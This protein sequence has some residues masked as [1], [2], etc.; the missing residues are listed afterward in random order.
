MQLRRILTAFFIL[1]LFLVSSLSV[2]ARPTVALQSADYVQSGTLNLA[3]PNCIDSFSQFTTACYQ[4]WY[5]LQTMF[6]DDGVPTAIGLDHVAVQ[7]YSSNS[8][9]SV[10]YFNV[11]PG[12]TWSDDVP[13][14]AT[15]LAYSIQQMFANYSWAAG[16]LLT[17]I[18]L[19]NGSP[20]T[21][22]PGRHR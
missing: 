14:N 4:P 10:W 11:T 9:G 6:P 18:G 13:A 21:A 5:F 20:Q 2:V 17:Y 12:M 7:S 22:I 15:D 3:M 8:N 16:S 1:V 19:L